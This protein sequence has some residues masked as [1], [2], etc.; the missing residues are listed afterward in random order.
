MHVRLSLVASALAASL[1]LVACVA[2]PAR[3]PAPAAARSPAP[4]LERQIARAAEAPPLPIDPLEAWLRQNEPLTIQHAT[5]RFPE[6]VTVFTRGPVLAPGNH[7]AV[8]KALAERI[9]AFEKLPTLDFVALGQ[10]VPSRGDARPV[11][12]RF[13]SLTLRFAK[14]PLDGAC[15]DPFVRISVIDFLGSS[16]AERSAR[17]VEQVTVVCVRANDDAT[18]AAPPRVHTLPAAAAGSLPFVVLCDTYSYAWGYEHFGTVVDKRG[19]VYSF[20]GSPPFGGASAHELAVMM[21]Y[22]K[23]YLNTMAP[24]AVDRLVALAPLIA[25]EPLRSKKVGD[26][27][28]P[29]SG[30]TLFTPGSAPDALVSVRLDQSGAI[31]LRRTGPAS[32]EA[33]A[34]LSR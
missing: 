31:V 4:P 25:K 5:Q 19:D 28:R 23:K 9:A 10:T 34:I 24:A 12:E 17:W 6:S 27:D 30:C 32:R 3:P 18:A 20:D 26:T 1:M 11:E 16:P 13:N 21:R 8:V 15:I 2:P 7:V 29:G 33:R 14:P 22:Q